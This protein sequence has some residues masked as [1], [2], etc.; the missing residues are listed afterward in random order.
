VVELVLQKIAHPA[1]LRT[2]RKLTGE[3]LRTFAAHIGVSPDVVWRSE[4]GDSLVPMDLLT[5]ARLH[6]GYAD[7]GVGITS[8]GMVYAEPRQ[9]A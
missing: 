6:Q 4:Q 9:A 8:D 5:L 3:S 1:V 7:F 2:A